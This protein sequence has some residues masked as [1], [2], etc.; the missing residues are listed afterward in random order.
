[1]LECCGYRLKLPPL[2]DAAAG[3]DEMIFELGAPDVKKC[4]P[5]C[6]GA[7]LDKVAGWAAPRPV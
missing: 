5:R 1:L 4:W 2:L 3:K 6:G 7:A